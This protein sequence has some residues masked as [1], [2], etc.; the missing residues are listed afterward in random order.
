MG[1]LPLVRDSP[2]SLPCQLAPGRIYRWRVS[3]SGS[4]PVPPSW[5][6]PDVTPENTVER[7][8]FMFMSWRFRLDGESSRFS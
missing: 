2:E 7:T 5:P 3:C 1:F 4:R 6:I 8:E